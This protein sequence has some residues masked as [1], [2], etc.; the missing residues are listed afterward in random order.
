VL[1]I[2]PEGYPNIDPHPTPKSDLDAFLPF[3]PGFL[4]MAEL[5]E[6]DGHTHVAIVPAGLAYAKAEGRHRRH[7][8]AVVRYGPPLYLSDFASAEE[9][10]RVVEEQVHALSS[11]TFVP[12]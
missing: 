7:W 9:M 10:I 3:R 1:L 4:R 11:S 8:R 5:A 2:F 12:E 6:R